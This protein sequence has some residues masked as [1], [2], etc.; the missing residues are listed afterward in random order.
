MD[1]FCCELQ[2]RESSR[3]PQLASL[4]GV[5]VLSCWGDFVWVI[6][7]WSY[8][9]KQHFLNLFL[10]VLDLRCCTGISLVAERRLEGA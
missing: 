2:L 7:S 8:V 5:R 9:S 6:M 4:R 1:W 10:A 3:E